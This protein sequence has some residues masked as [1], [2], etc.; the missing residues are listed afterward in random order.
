MSKFLFAECS[1]SREQRQKGGYGSIFWMRPR[2]GW[3]AT[4]LSCVV[5]LVLLPKQADRSVREIHRLRPNEGC[6]TEPALTCDLLIPRG[7]LLDEELP[8]STT[9]ND[10]CKLGRAN[11]RP[12]GA[13]ECSRE[14][15]KCF[16]DDASLDCGRGVP[17][18][19]LQ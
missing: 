15:V 6:R 14:A 19:E 5:R 9:V 16:V 12:A 1:I 3:Y 4:R 8:E 7:H 13:S 10:A 17:L 11:R 18:W 2:S